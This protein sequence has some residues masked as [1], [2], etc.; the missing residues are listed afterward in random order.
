MLSTPAT[1]FIKKILRVAANC[2][3]ILSD[4][5]FTTWYG[6]RSPPS[7]LNSKVITYLNALSIVGY[8]N[9][10]PT[11]SSHNFTHHNRRYSCS[12]PHFNRCF[13][14][15]HHFPTSD[16]NLSDHTPTIIHLISPEPIPR[17]SFLETQS[18]VPH[19]IQHHSSHSLPA[20]FTPLS[21]SLILDRWKEIKH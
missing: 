19:W 10:A 2:E 12:S 4:F 15:L 9:L 18:T 14:T 11:G 6:N 8:T 5:N 17:V 21:P 20:H 16:K 1:T 13:S 3:L 7:P